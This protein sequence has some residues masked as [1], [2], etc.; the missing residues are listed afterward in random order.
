MIL[1]LKELF[2]VLVIS[3]IVFRLARPVALKFIAGDDF[4]RRC[5][6][7]YLLT[8]TA[9]LS[10][11]F[12][13]FS[14]VAVPT[15]IIAGRR[16]SNPGALYLML[17]QVIPP[18]DVPVPLFGI[19]RLIEVNNYLLLS[20]CVM[21]PAAIRIIRSSEKSGS[22]GFQMTDAC[23]LAYGLLTSLLYVQS[24]TPEGG[25]YAG[26]VME[27]V[28]RGVVFA[29]SVYVP[30]FAI[31]RASSSRKALVD[32]MASFC[33][34]CALLAAIAVFET[35]RHWL[36]YNEM[37]YRWNDTYTLTSYLERGGSLRA[38]ASTGHSMALGYMLVIGWG[39]WL[40]LRSSVESTRMRLGGT[41][42]FWG[43][44][45]AS[46]TRG[47]WV[48]AVIVYFLYAAIGPLAL[49][50]MAKAV[51]VSIVTAVLIYFS[52]LADRIM[53]VLP[54]LGGTVDS[55]NIVYR[56]RLFDRAW[57]IIQQSPMLGDQGALLKMQDLRQGQGIIDLVNT[58]I[59]ILLDNGFV[60]L[61]LF[62]LF[63]LIPL[64]KVLSATRRFKTADQDRS[65]LGA[66][67]ASTIIAMLVILESGNFLGGPQKIFYA[68]I[69]LA[70]AY[71]YVN[72][73]WSQDN[74]LHS[75]V[76]GNRAI[77]K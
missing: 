71:A 48:G 69:A 68:L 54:F 77:P 3:A 31:S 1:S 40:Y 76:I 2:V 33:L 44:F 9:F 74:Q 38:M 22:R 75:P 6:V 46:F 67:L 24:Q 60:G 51:G 35:G 52:P 4:S 63:C 20:I 21:T 17:L 7:W 72:R 10:P 11:S 47:A 56:H 28:R 49:S 34:S 12:L 26:T 61:T 32:A 18:V 64:F 15:L 8:V 57:E 27:S 29:L 45:L 14:V 37:T 5:K 66:C 59:G 13:I 23:L 62:L 25:L 39:F 16:D 55:G 73:V 70:T 42:L 30:Y 36:L 53:S 43:G 65:M 58:Y 50:K 19:D 41:I